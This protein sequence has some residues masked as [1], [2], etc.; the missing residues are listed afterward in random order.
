[1]MNKIDGVKAAEG[2]RDILLPVMWFS[3]E[4]DKFED[5]E[6]IQRIK[7]CNDSDVCPRTAS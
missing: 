4:V 5:P 1:M 7:D 3:D 2:L 6:L